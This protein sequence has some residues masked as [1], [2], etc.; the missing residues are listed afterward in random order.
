MEIGMMWWSLPAG[1]LME[2]IIRAHDYYLK[3]YNNSPNVCQVHPGMID[4]S[5]NKISGIKV[6]ASKELLPNHLWIGCSE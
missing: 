4:D 6:S 5:I 1:T 2:R 3:K